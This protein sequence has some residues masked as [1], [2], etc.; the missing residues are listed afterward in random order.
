M[1]SIVPLCISLL[2]AVTSTLSS[3]VPVRAKFFPLASLI[4]DLSS[5]PILRLNP[6]QSHSA[7]TPS[8]VAPTVQA[9]VSKAP[10]PVQVKASQ[11]QQLVELVEVE[12]RLALRPLLAMVCLAA[13]R[14]RGLS[15]GV[16]TKALCTSVDRWCE[17]VRRRGLVPF[18]FRRFE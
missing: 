15:A 14:G 10:P 17:R 16:L 9:V 2:L 13:L 6:V 1:L 7:D 5:F 3:P 18:M 12:S 11:A 8:Q 4:T